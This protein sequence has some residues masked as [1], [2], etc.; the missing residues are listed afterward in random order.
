MEQFKRKLET[1]IDFN[2]KEFN[3]NWTED[4]IKSLERK[5]KIKLPIDYSFYLQHYGNDYIKEEYRFIPSEDLSK[6]MMLEEIEVESFYGLYNDENAIDNKIK[7]YKDL[8]LE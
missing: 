3:N 2:V 6:I 7:L 4:H 8:L 1:I 5:Y